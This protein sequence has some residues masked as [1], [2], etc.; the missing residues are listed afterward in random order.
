MYFYLKPTEK[1]GVKTNTDHEMYYYIKRSMHA[2][3]T[4]AK[5][6]TRNASR[7]SRNAKRFA[8]NAER[9]P[10]NFSHKKTVCSFFTRFDFRFSRV[11][12]EL[13]SG[14]KSCFKMSRYNIHVNTDIWQW[15]L[16]QNQKDWLLMKKNNH[17]RDKKKF[18]QNMYVLVFI[19]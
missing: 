11:L 6:F 5:R 18:L 15:D 17:Y 14:G 2:R 1:S 9:L 13:F 3:Y 4:L 8:R 16:F 7:F 12:S 10:R 19:A